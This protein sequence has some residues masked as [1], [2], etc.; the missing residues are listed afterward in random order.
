MT[1]KTMESRM[2]YRQARGMSRSTIQSHLA[3]KFVIMFEFRTP[4]MFESVAVVKEMAE[5][6]AIVTVLV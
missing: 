1:E 5:I 2:G 4:T 3:R 6:G